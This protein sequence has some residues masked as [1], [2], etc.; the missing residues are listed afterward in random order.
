MSGL[1]QMVLKPLWIEAWIP[2]WNDLEG[3]SIGVG[4]KLEDSFALSLGSP[5]LAGT[6]KPDAFKSLFPDTS[7]SLGRPGSA[8]P[9][10]CLFR[11]LGLVD[12]MGCLICNLSLVTGRFS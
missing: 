6:T 11:I 7:V 3:L 12:T 1:V 9:K 5:G 8:G 10:Q 4:P 2:W